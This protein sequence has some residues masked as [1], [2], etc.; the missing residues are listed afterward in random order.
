MCI[1]DRHE[2]VTIEDDG[3]AGVVPTGVARGVVKRKSQAINDFAF[4]FVAPLGA[5][6]RN[7]L[8]SRF[9]RQRRRST[10]TRVAPCPLRL[11]RETLQEG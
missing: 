11:T 10:T 4:P 2:A 5:D 1:R 9:I 3:V 8:G 6:N 7:R